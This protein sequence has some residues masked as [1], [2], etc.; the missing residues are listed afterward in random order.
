MVDARRS[1]ARLAWDEVVATLLD[2]DKLRVGLAAAQAAHGRAQAERQQRERALDGRLGEL[3]NRL[4]RIL[5]DQ[6]AVPP[7][8]ER[9]RIYSEKAQAAECELERL[10]T[11]RADLSAQPD[12]GLSD[13]QATSLVAFAADVRTGIA[14]ATMADKQ[15]ICQ[16]LQLEGTVRVDPQRGIRLGQR[17]A[18]TVE[19]AANLP[20]RGNVRNFVNI[21]T[22]VLSDVVGM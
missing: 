11:E 20:I 16:L 3:R 4:A 7:A 13:E 21:K 18:F 10:Q 19:W 12:T 5:D 2:P 8:S 14:A 1:I 22:I 9:A 15:R 17:H 6:H